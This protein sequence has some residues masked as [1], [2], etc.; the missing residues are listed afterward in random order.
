MASISDL[1]GTA[2][3]CNTVTGTASRLGA[4]CTIEIYPNPAKDNITVK[5]AG[6]QFHV[7][8]IEV[9]DIIGRT[10][11]QVTVGKQ[12]MVNIPGSQLKPGLYIIRFNGDQTKTQRVV[13]Q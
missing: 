2:N 10:L 12:T 8:T 6:N 3:N 13:I 11:T 5:L 7:K 9:V 4:N 1:G